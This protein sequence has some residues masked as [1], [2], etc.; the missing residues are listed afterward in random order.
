MKSRTQS[1]RPVYLLCLLVGA[2]ACLTTGAHAAKIVFEPDIEYANPDNQHLKLDLARPAGDDDAPQSVDGA[3]P[4]AALRPAVVCIHGGGFRA[5][6]R[7]GYDKMCKTLAEHG[8]VAVTVEYRLSP[9]YQFPAAIEDVKTAVRWMRQ[10][11]EKYHVDP[12]RIASLGGSAGGHLAQFLG[13]TGDVHR[14]DGTQYLNQSSKVQCVINYYGPEDFTKSY[15]R[16]VDAAEVLPMWLGG[17]LEHARAKHVL[18][19]PINWVTPD[20]APTLLLH[21]TEDK[22]VNYEQATWMYDRMK[23]MGLDVELLTLKGAGHG[24]GG[25]YAQ[26]A[27]KAAIQFLDKHLKKQ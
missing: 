4:A 6:D 17:D 16:S 2:L 5:G 24:F 21:G 11:A 19:S 22:Y 14:F 20:A 3:R 13:V 9:K 10:N 7:H 27:D 18:A 26:Q 15:G 12:N 25:K 1:A 8:Y 23:S